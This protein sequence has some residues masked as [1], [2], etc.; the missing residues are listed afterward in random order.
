MRR[1]ILL[2]D[3]S[4]TIQRLVT[5][6]FADGD[7]DIV[8]V[9]NGEAAIRKFDEVQPNVVLADIYMPGKNGY[10]VCAY[11][12]QHPR[13]GSTPVVLLVG[14]FDAFDEEKARE[15]GATSNITKPFEPQALVSLVESVMPD[16][17]MPVRA[18]VAVAAVEAPAVEVTVAE[19]Q[20]PVSM[21]AETVAA[22][23]Q[24]EPPMLETI[25]TYDELMPPPVME[26]AAPQPPPAAAAEPQPPEIEPQD[27]DLLGLE[28]LFVEPSPT[29]SFVLSDQDID[30]IADRVIQRISPQVI[31]SLAWEI[32]PDLTERIVREELQRKR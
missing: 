9:S 12:R 29:P 23:A 8:S 4:P 25:A 16:S 28:N 18:P 21:V 19:P 27:D 24:P 6:T 26:M 10:E 32:V 5:N 30:R 14:A 1:T 3:D 31:E 17:E 15:A 2:A 11:I 20:E 22:S 13:L 7:Y